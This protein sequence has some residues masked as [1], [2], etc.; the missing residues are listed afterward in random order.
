MSKAKFVFACLG[1]VL[2][3]AAATPAHAQNNHSFISA[4][5]SGTACTF[6]AP[7]ADFDGAFNATVAGGLITCLDPGGNSGGG[8][9]NTGITITKSI[10]LD[11][12]GAAAGS[13]RILVN[14][15]GIVVTLRNLNIEG[16]GGTNASGIDF[17]N[18][19]VLNVD[20][21]L[22]E[23]FTGNSGNIGIIFEP[24]AAAELHITDS[25]I[26]NNFIGINVTP[27][28]NGS[29]KGT[30][31]RT[32][33]DNNSSGFQANG[34]N[35]LVLVEIKDST[36]ANNAADGVSATTSGST[37]SIV[38]NRS[39]SDHNGGRGVVTQGNGA[40]VSLYASTVDWNSTGLSTNGGTILS[41]QN[42]MIAGNL[43]PGVTPLSFSQ[44]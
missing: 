1:I 31:D 6:Q 42:N 20:H 24:S 38:L 9:T 29:A 34:S 40:F 5:G 21:C 8:F 32:L 44:Q 17:T 36:I 2:S 12:G 25:I 3:W 14:G 10:T 35:G 43:N 22:I 27:Q 23:N 39:S 11:C 18:G 13:Y 41:Y 30:I 19:A 28:G 16:A 33:V 7:C 15:S 26:Q 4:N 37:T